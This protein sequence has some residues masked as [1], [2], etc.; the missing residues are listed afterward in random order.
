MFDAGVK[1][2]IN[3][4]EDSLCYD[5]VDRGQYA[6]ISAEGMYY[7][8][9]GDKLKFKFIG[10]NFGGKTGPFNVRIIKYNF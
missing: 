6:H 10:Y 2:L 7:L 8:N 1:L 4:K 5:L 3:E 9:A